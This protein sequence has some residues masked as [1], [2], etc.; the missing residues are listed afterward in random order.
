[1]YLLNTMR[2]VKEIII[3]FRKEILIVSAV[4]LL[5]FF[6]SYF[7][8]TDSSV[9]GYGRSGRNGFSTS[10]WIL[11]LCILAGIRVYSIYKRK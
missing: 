8:N 1:M 5:V 7:T 10:V 3:Y 11:G 4:I 2:R 9:Y 6:I